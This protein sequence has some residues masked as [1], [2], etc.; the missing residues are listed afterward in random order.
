MPH[1]II[2]AVQNGYTDFGFIDPDISQENEIVLI[3][4]R[5]SENQLQPRHHLIVF[6]PTSVNTETSRLYI[7]N[8]IWNRNNNR[9]GNSSYN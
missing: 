7:Y 5:D 4:R 1:F 2:L 3:I 8:A 9:R 6:D